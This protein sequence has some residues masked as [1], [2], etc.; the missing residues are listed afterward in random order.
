MQKQPDYFSFPLP[1]PQTLVGNKTKIIPV[2]GR[3]PNYSC[4]APF[5][6][7]KKKEV[8]IMEKKQFHV[9]HDY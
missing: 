4:V 8:S 7:G 6:Q 9:R 3:V 5:L 2:P 1:A